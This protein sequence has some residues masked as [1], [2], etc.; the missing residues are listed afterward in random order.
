VSPVI[1]SS[2]QA[3]HGLGLP[4]RA[5]PFYFPNLYDASVLGEGF[6]DLDISTRD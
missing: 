2:K 1:R 6:Q 4:I 3:F 5:L